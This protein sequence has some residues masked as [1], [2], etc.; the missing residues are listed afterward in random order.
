[1][2]LTRGLFIILLVSFASCFPGSAWK[3]SPF[4]VN[5]ASKLIMPTYLAIESGNIVAYT[6]VLD[7]PSNTTMGIYRWNASPDS[8]TLLGSQIVLFASTIENPRIVILKDSFRI[9]YYQPG[10]V[11][12]HEMWIRKS[13]LLP[14]V[15]MSTGTQTGGVYLPMNDLLLRR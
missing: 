7:L 14:L 5:P 4:S 1:M 2:T 15:F 12:Y 13:D 10:T 8:P 6:L 3:V 11:T 9:D